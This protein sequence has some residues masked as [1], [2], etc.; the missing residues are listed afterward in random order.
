MDA[1]SHL[2]KR[3]H[4]LLFENVNVPFADPSGRAAACLLSLWVRIQT[5]AW[6][7]FCCE[8][9]VLSGRGLCDELITTPEDS[10]RTWCVVV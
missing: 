4:F 2:F 10:Y 6:M 9:R 1:P 7:F 8:C 3:R 5:G